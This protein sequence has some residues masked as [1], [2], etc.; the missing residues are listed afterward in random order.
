MDMGRL[1]EAVDMLFFRRKQIE[2]IFRSGCKGFNDIL[3][4]ILKRSIEQVEEQNRD[5]GI[6]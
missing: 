1:D 6:R 2:I 3:H 4:W 5:F